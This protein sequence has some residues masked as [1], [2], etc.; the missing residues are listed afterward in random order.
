MDKKTKLK[1]G[2]FWHVDM[3]YKQNW[4]E[5]QAEY[6]CSTIIYLLADS[7]LTSQEIGGIASCHTSLA[8]QRRR[9][10]IYMLQLA[11]DIWFLAQ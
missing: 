8:R 4:L 11:S 9:N 6:C 5:Y 2:L 7:L 3:F 1:Y 10:W